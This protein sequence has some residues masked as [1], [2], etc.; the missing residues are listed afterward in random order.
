LTVTKQQFKIEYPFHWKDKEIPLRDI[1]SVQFKRSIYFLTMLVIYKKDEAEFGEAFK[2][3][4]ISNNS[5]MKLK[6]YFEKE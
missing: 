4:G 1:S 5:L 6:T 3:I 2:L